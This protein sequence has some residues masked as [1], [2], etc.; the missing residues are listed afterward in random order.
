MRF[1]PRG[2][3]VTPD[4]R[5]HGPDEK[6]IQTSPSQPFTNELCVPSLSALFLHYVYRPLYIGHTLF[7]SVLQSRK[8]EIDG[9]LL[10]IITKMLLLLLGLLIVI[11]ILLLGVKC[12]N[13]ADDRRKV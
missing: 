10:T 8:S 1:R 13:M 12:L 5:H 4:I 9:T 6:K 2:G 3:S 11:H 7:L